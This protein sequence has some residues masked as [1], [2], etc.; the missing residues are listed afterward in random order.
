MAYES[1]LER[2]LAP[3]DRTYE[4]VTS[5]MHLVAGRLTSPESDWLNH[6]I[7]SFANE[8]DKWPQRA[9]LSDYLLRTLF[10]PNKLMQLVAGAYLHI[11]FDLPRALASDWPMQG[12]WARGPTEAEAHSL[13]FY[14][15]PIFPK[16]MLEVTKDIRTVGLWSY[17]LRGR[18]RRQLLPAEMWVRFLRTGAWTHAE[19]L[20]RI[21]NRQYVEQQ[22]ASAMTAALQDATLAAPWSV[23]GLA[24]PTSAFYSVAVPAILVDFSQ[25]APAAAMGAILAATLTQFLVWSRVRSD[26][27][28]AAASAFAERLGYLVND[29]VS[30]AVKNPEGFEDY[31]QRRRQE[32]GLSRRSIIFRPGLR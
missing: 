26:H 10:L 19:Q 15:E 2:A 28:M 20:R 31:R 24:P 23:F 11:S 8:R 3:F 29:Y 4:R 27:E 13:Y 22:M 16:T 5:Q 14:L 21:S 7:E 12:R 18:T 1:D 17:I 25:Y 32:L 6:L 30:E 9:E